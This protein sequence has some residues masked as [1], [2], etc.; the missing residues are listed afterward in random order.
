[1]ASIS[2]VLKAIDQ[3][4][5]VITGLNQGFEL[6][7][8]SISAMKVIA[9]AAF[10]GIK[11]AAE[12]AFE[13]VNKAVELA[14]K[15]GEFDEARNQ[16]EFLAKSYSKNGQEI[17][18]IIKDISGNTVTEFQAIPVAT[19][20]LAAELTGDQM[21][22]VLTYTK[23]WS[24]A[25]GQ[26]FESLASQVFEA[27]SRGKY[28][29][30]KTMDL[31]IESGEKVSSIVDKMGAGLVKFGDT[32][33]NTADKV[34]SL[35]VAWDDFTTKIGQAINQNESWQKIFTE[36]EAAVVSFVKGFNPAP[37]KD[38]FD[39]IG[40]KLL[41][42]YE[43]VKNRITEFNITWESSWKKIEEITNASVAAVV[44]TVAFIDK[45]LGS[46]F[47]LEGIIK[48]FLDFSQAVVDYTAIAAHAVVG[49]YETSASAFYGII[50]LI[51]K[52]TVTALKLVASFADFIGIDIT[53]SN[54]LDTI[55]MLDFT[56]KGFEQSLKDVGTSANGMRNT[57]DEAAKAS[58]GAIESIR[59]TSKDLKFPISFEIKMAEFQVDYG[60]IVDQ[61]NEFNKTAKFI[62][63]WEAKKTA[64]EIESGIADLKAKWPG[65]VASIGNLNIKSIINPVLDTERFK[66]IFDSVNNTKFQVRIGFNP[67]DVESLQQ[68]MSNMM[69]SVMSIAGGMG[70][71]GD[72][73]LKNMLK[74]A[75]SPKEEMRQWLSSV[76]WPSE[77]QSLGEF[78]MTWMLAK[79]EGESVPMAI[80]T[81]LGGG[82]SW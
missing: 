38:F 27:F 21:E 3:Y 10:S 26:N 31:T 78:M 40:A 4:S 57:I 56:T 5:G 9:D 18:D 69:A 7:G 67:K 66:E 65:M 53:G 50:L 11:L 61:I 63:K 37:V 24:E 45:A 55:T 71:T 39:G 47:T 51:E 64:E 73:G 8:K 74:T 6:V 15:G 33:F 28:S 23:K 34:T 25:N 32:G 19:K 82:A 42:F 58:T 68:D 77:L 70:L 29:V 60:K 36:V 49:F 16:F 72:M 30:L 14:T 44:K 17:I 52:T 13:G 59:E 48:A 22:K 1:M 35:T 12:T 79:A 80:T 43:V 75:L 62:P 41:Y 81:D 46:G 2:I 76:N 54:L 20:A